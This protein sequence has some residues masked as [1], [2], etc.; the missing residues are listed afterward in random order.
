MIGSIYDSALERDGWPSVL[1]EIG[2]VLDGSW[3]LM[4]MLRLDGT[5]TLNIQDAASDPHHL[6]VFEQ[7]FTSPETNPAVARLL[8]VPPGTF[9]L[10]EH[11]M[12]DSEW[13]RHPM[14]RELYE[15]V[16]LRYGLGALILKTET[17]MVPLGVN[18]TRK[19]GPFTPRDFD[20]LAELVPHLRRALGVVTKIAELSGRRTAYETLWDRLPHGVVL[21]DSDA[22]LIWANRSAWAIVRA[23]DGIDLHKGRLRA[24]AHAENEALGRLILA[25][26]TAPCRTLGGEGDAVSVSRPSLLRPYSLLVAP[27]KIA[28]LE[29]GRAPA[30]VVILTDPEERSGAQ[31]S[32]LARLFRLTPREA[33]LAALL[34]EGQGLED[35]AE[36]LRLSRNTARQHLRALFQKTGTHRQ[37]ELV[38]L[39][40]RSAAGLL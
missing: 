2:A 29:F 20:L 13:K 23:G 7:G 38:R 36:R 5:A 30:A 21:L 6:A 37:A 34:M 19:Q 16:G 12:S 33:A 10:P 3:L 26:A 24:A 39:L 14:Y 35:I 1:S 27:V 9:I 31:P 17:H 32:R 40:L 22:K 25:A 8:T 11:E 4:G 28:P 18:R 15:P